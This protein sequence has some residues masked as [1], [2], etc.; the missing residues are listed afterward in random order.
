[1]RQTF[2]RLSKLGGTTDFNTVPLWTSLISIF[3]GLADF[4]K[5]DNFSRS[6][7]DNSAENCRSEL[8]KDGKDASQWDLDLSRHNFYSKMNSSA[9]I[10]EKPEKCKK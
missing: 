3:I 6:F 9:V 4:R 2:S 7:R 10:L 8:P 1:M 5:F